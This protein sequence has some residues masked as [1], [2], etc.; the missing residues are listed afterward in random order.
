MEQTKVFIKKH[1]PF[2]IILRRNIQN[3]PFLLRS[4]NAI[5]TDIY[6]GNKWHDN[7][8]FSGSGSNL[9]QTKAIREILPELINNLSIKTMLDIPCG[10][11][12]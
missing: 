5:F 8:S 7:E 1:F 12:F 3:L 2:L 9:E 11:F 4:Y 10:D 6:K